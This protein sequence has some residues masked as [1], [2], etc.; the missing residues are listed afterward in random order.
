MAL[1]QTILVIRI[2]SLIVLILSCYLL[3]LS[4]LIHSC[5]LESENTGDW[6]STTESTKTVQDECSM[7][8]VVG[9]NII[10][11]TCQI[12]LNHVK[13]PFPIVHFV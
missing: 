1:A 10:L 6:F 13:P 11:L 12:S 4:S 3:S 8:H 7:G 5:N 9:S 2:N